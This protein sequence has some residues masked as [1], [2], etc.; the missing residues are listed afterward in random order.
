MNLSEITIKIV[1]N[2]SVSFRIEFLFKDDIILFKWQHFIFRDESLN[3]SADELKQNIA[4]YIIKKKIVL[5]ENV[6]SRN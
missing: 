4:I 3:L 5:F 1:P 6:R 2:F